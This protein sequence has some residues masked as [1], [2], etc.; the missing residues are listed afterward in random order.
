MGGVKTGKNTAI[1]SNCYFCGNYVRIGANCF[2]NNFCKFY[3]Y[4]NDDSLIEIED[5]VT[6]A[7][8]VVFCTH[9]HEVGDESRRAI[10]KTVVAPIKIGAGTWIGAN[11]IILPGVSVGRGCVIA[12]GAVVN[13]NCE[14]NCIYGGVPATLIKRL[15]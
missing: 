15:E 6:I 14:D 11:A 1:H 5:N 13:R 3:S 10:R 9:T 4:S 2:V 12:A 8:N 7:M